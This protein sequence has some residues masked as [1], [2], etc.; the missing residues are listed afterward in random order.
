MSTPRR[1]APRSSGAPMMA[2]FMAVVLHHH[3]ARRLTRPRSKLWS[4]AQTSWWRCPVDRE[5]LESAAAGYPYL[6]G[7]LSV[8]LG[9]MLVL[10]ALGN[11]EVGPLRNPWAF[12]AAAAAIGASA[13]M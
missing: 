12:V 4:V 2:A 8:P 5:H 10:A 11:W 1:P 7:L 13:L 3:A 9:L 6:R